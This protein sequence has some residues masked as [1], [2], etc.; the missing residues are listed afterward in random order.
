M[1]RHL[2]V[3]QS[4]RKIAVIFEAVILENKLVSCP[5][6]EDF[7]FLHLEVPLSTQ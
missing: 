6:L 5:G 1:S 2:G 7:A 3:M 4:R